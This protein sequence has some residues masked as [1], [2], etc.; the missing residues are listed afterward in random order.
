MRPLLA[1][2]QLID[3]RV[4][5]E[6]RRLGR[7]AI[8]LEAPATSLSTEAAV[9]IRD[10]SRSGLLI[11]TDAPFSHG[12]IFT[13]ALPEA[14]PVTAQICWQRGR[15]FGCVFLVPVASS[16]VSAALLS[17]PAEVHTDPLTDELTALDPSTLASHG[18]KT[19]ESGAPQPLLSFTTK[20][21]MALLLLTLLLLATRQ[22][23]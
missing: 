7:R 12:E 8:Y 23:S 9:V 10:I 13:I 11:E 6:R 21:L 14:G 4:A 19:N 5:A 2:V 1:R 22:R 18:M 3:D 20:V 15:Q 16:A 17:T